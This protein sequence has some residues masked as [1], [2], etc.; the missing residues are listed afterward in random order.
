MTQHAL[1][2]WAV[3]VDGVRGGWVC[4][5]RGCD[6][7]LAWQ[8]VITL[9][10]L[11]DAVLPG[12]IVAVDMPLGLPVVGP[13]TCD[14]VARRLLPGRASSVFPAPTRATAAD[15]REGVP[16]HE[17]VARARGRGHRA[18]SRQTWLITDKVNDVADAVG[19]SVARVVECHPELTF[20]QMAGEVLPR[21]ATTAGVGRR[22]VA[23]REW[24]DADAALATA[25]DGVP[26]VDALDALACL[27]T[28]ERVASTQATSVGDERAR[29]WV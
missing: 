20:A 3:G 14:V 17:A 19:S 8:V 28:A 23:L 25:P 7:S 4:A 2:P 5:I 15:R 6:G 27:W 24:C 9:R 13:R 18:P 16:Y 10:D 1:E 22:L 29:I 26:V 21:K 11:L 12:C